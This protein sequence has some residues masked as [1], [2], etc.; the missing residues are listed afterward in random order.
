MHWVDWAIMLVPLLMVL[1]MAFYSGRYVRGVADFLAAGRVAGR[2][3]MS[4]GDLISGLSVITLV[5][6]CESKYQTGY[7]VEFWGK[8]FAPVGIIFFSDRILRLPLERNQSIVIRT[9]S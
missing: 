9:I 2:Y 7:G 6:L 1:G 4:V 8:P 3:V 5:A